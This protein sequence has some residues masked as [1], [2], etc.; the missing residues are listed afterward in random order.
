[1]LY[2]FKGYVKIN[3]LKTSKVKKV[4]NHPKSKVTLLKS[5]KTSSEFLR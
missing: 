5:I 4:A 2:N 1:M 3:F